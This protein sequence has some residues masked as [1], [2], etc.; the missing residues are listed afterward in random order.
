MVTLP[1]AIVVG[2]F[3]NCL[4]VTKAPTPMLALL[5]FCHACPAGITGL[6]MSRLV[7]ASA[8]VEL[9]GFELPLNFFPESEDPSE[10]HPLFSNALDQDDMSNGRAQLPLTTLREFRMMQLIDQLT[11]KPDWHKKIFDETI[12]AKWKAEVLSED[13]ENDVGVSEKMVDW[14]IA[15]LRY[16]TKTFERIGAINVYD[17]DVVKSDK[18]IP[19][20][21]KEALKIAAARLERVPEKAKD[22]HPESDEKVLDLVH[23][24]LFPLVYGLSRILPDS[25]VGLDDCIRMTGQGV[26][27]PVPPENECYLHGPPQ[28]R[29]PSYYHYDDESFAKP[30]SSMFQWLPCD[31]DISGGEGSVKITSYINNLHPEKHRDLYAV[32]EQVIARAIPLW[33]LSLTPVKLPLA[34]NRVKFER[35]E[36][37]ID[38]YAM[39]DSEGPQRE[40]G[41][42]EYAWMDRREEW[43]RQN[44]VIT[45]PEPGDFVPRSVAPHISNPGEYFIEDTHELKPEKTVD[46]WRDHGQRGLQ[47]IVKLANIHLTPE[48]PEYEGGTW[49]V[50]GQL[51]EHI[52]AS[53]VYYYDSDNITT[54]RL[55]FRQQSSTDGVD[56]FVYPQN[57]HDF[58][59][60]IFG[61]EANDS[62]QDIG[63]V[64]TPEGRLLTWPNIL[65]HQVQPFSLENRSKP[66]HRKILALFL[67]DPHIRIISSANVPCQQREWWSEMVRKGDNAISA[68]P[69]EL[70]D[71][72]FS[73]VEDF[74]ISLGKAKQL[75][76]ELMKERAA[77]V[78]QHD[79]SFHQFTFSL[80]EH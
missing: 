18:A 53:A 43:C 6:S 40:D 46:L 74:P 23:P 8:R 51:N 33:N 22:W 52:C 16:K 15:E 79:R 62:V 48:K 78:K 27:I 77:Y 76:L 49:H 35:V 36:Y 44:R 17:G 58:M 59:E 63:T 39:S 28:S 60:E 56:D 4:A 71:K 2:S 13:D 7:M 37:D 34:S 32:I 64:N 69:A 20:S 10:D 5:G 54:S 65:Q 57:D 19:E 45:Q 42:D 9:P 70:Q 72:I 21:L 41:E 24:S 31:V 12:V 38:L 73:D 26:T 80:C 25:R 29:G 14:C 67:V 68:L 75:R 1:C 11:D 50:E 47:I 30:F 55:A 66:G 61:C 3:H